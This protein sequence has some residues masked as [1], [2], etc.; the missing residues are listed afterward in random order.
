[1]SESLYVKSEDYEK[2]KKQRD[3]LLAACK[4]ARDLYDQLALGPLE[5]AAKY[6]DSYIPPSDEDWLNMRTK[7]ETAIAKAEP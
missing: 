4:W 6:G 2:L 7:L 5:A 3:D 1:M